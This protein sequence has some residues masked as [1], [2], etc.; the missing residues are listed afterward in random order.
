MMIQN[1]L[2][3][4]AGEDPRRIQGLHRSSISRLRAYAIALHIPVGLWAVSGYLIGEKIFALAIGPAA[5]VALCAA[6]AIYLVERLILATPRSW[7]M[8]LG[9]LGIGLVTALIG[10]SA[11]DLV[12]FDR[13]V[14][15]QLRR[16][17]VQSLS[18]SYDRAIA[19]N[20]QRTELLRKEWLRVQ[21]LANCEANGTCGSRI[22]STGP[23]FRELTKQAEVLRKDYLDVL[24]QTDALKV[25][26]GRAIESVKVSGDV[27][28][29]A[30]LLA[31]V[32]ALH[33][34]TSENRT[35]FVAWV[36]FFSLVLSFELM[37]VFVKL[38]FPPTVDDQIEN[39]RE[40][41]SYMKARAFRVA[42]LSPLA[43]AR[44]LLESGA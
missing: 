10:A 6:I 23:I 22:R 13:E 16:T 4:V 24:G 30:G 40:E 35:A 8:N 12:I 43:S 25:D 29:R 36:L 9:R 17:E 20:Q 33:L 32:E 21:A 34:Y 3:L 31:R 26:K 18:T 7:C 2:C 1:Y 37:V 5:F 11:V 41:I 42:V 44:A 28:E 15:E 19:D 39:M 38:V 14:A 27:V